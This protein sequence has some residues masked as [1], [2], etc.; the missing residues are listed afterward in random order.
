MRLG[1][2]AKMIVDE[3]RRLRCGRIVMATARKNSIT[4]MLQDSVT[5]KVLE[6]TNVPV[7]IVAGDDVS[8]LERWG[9]PAGLGAAIALLL[10]AAD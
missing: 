2:K 8:P 5:N 1:E 9:L 7:E 3:A 4:R 10:A 6:Q